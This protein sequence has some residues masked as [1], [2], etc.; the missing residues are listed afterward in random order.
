MGAHGLAFAVSAHLDAPRARLEI[1]ALEGVFEE[2][3]QQITAIKTP[4][5]RIYRPMC[6]RKK[7]AN[8]L[9]NIEDDVI[10]TLI[11]WLR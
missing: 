5:F 4:H 1:S 9:I 2:E 10:A 6:R 8:D 11:T 3:K 7:T